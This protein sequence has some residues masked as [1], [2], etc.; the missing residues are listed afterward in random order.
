MRDLEFQGE[1]D[2]IWQRESKSQS[3]RDRNPVNRLVILWV[4]PW[5]WILLQVARGK[6]CF[7]VFKDLWTSETSIKIIEKGNSNQYE[8]E[9][10]DIILFNQRA[11]AINTLKSRD[12]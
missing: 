12:S 2:Q 9:F 6:I 1:Q 3:K 5:N 11:R 4:L 7:C 8:K 10:L